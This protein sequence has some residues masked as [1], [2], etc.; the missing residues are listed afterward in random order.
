M[1]ERKER[2]GRSFENT[3]SGKAVAFAMLLWVAS[4]SKYF[5]V[6]V[7]EAWKVGWLWEQEMGMVR[8]GKPSEVDFQVGT[9][10]C[11]G[12]WGKQECG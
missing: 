5:W 11:P 1:R 4:D 8:R 9:H 2:E 6:T 12:P 10:G 7:G 3:V